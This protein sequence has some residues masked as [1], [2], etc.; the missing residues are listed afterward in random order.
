LEANSYPQEPLVQSLLL[1]LVVVLG[2]G[3]LERGT[4]NRKGEG[5]PAISCRLLTTCR[6]R[7]SVVKKVL[8]VRRLESTMDRQGTSEDTNILELKRSHG[9]ESGL[10]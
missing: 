5:I 10:G 7:L 2:L 8:I 6:L 9:R 4:P 1:P 3:E